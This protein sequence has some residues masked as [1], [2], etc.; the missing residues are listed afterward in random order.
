MRLRLKSLQEGIPPSEKIRVDLLTPLI[1]ACYLNYYFSDI[2]ETRTKMPD[3]KRPKDSDVKGDGKKDQK[4]A[5]KEQVCPLFYYPRQHV[6][7]HRKG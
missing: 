3:K 2:Y 4:K 7:F 6:S 5:K 1:L